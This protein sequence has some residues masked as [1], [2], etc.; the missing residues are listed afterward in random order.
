MEIMLADKL[1]N[2]GCERKTSE[3]A[4]KILSLGLCE[5]LLPHVLI[6]VSRGTSLFNTRHSRPEKGVPRCTNQLRHP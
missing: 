4:V 1:E 5:L 6:Q 3:S 2:G